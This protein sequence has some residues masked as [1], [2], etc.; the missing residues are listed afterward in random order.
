MT[1]GRGVIS[2]WAWRAYDAYDRFVYP[3]TDSPAEQWQRIE[4]NA[5]VDAHI[6]RLDPTTR[7]AA[8]ISGEN[9]R[10]RPWLSYESLMYPDFDLCAPVELEQRFDVVICE[11]VLEHVP[12]PRQAAANLR[13]LCVPGGHVIVSTPFLI[14]VH[15]LLLFGMYDYW[16]FTPRGLRVLLEGAGLAVDSV[17]SWGNRPCVTGNLSRW[18]GYRRWLP[19]RNEPDVLV[20]VWAFARRIS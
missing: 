16:R 8:E 13:E 7:R 19:L 5:A 15:E 10:S 3:G 17:D 18:A 9:H 1:R 20:Q 14:R 2:R 6:G 4:L 12:D 11:Q